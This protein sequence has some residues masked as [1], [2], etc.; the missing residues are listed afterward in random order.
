MACWPMAAIGCASCGPLD[1]VIV[2]ALDAI[3]LLPRGGRLSPTAGETAS[4]ALGQLQRRHTSELFSYSSVGILAVLCLTL[5]AGP[6]DG[7]AFGLSC[8]P[9]WGTQCRPRCRGVFVCEHDAC[10]I[11]PEFQHGLDGVANLYERWQ[12]LCSWPL[13]TQ[14][15]LPCRNGVRCTGRKYIHMLD[16][17]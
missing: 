14:P 3:H 11:R 13:E 15:T 7:P 6:P 1:F 2:S 17:M 8:C 4:G 16:K 9:S 5:R 10:H 12:Q